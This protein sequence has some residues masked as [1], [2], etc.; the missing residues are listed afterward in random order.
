MP[1][2]G[3]TVILARKADRMLIAHTEFLAR[4][5]LSAARKLLASFRAART[6]LSENPLLYPY[7][8]DTDAGGHSSEQVSETFVLR[9]I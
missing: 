6:S 9:Q 7:A 2:K 1:N 3:Y 5:S 4:V 8:D